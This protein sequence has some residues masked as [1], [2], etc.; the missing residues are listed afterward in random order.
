VTLISPPPHHDIYSIED[1]AQLIYDLKQINPIARVCVKL[2][3]QSGIGTVAAGV[4]KA[5]DVILISGHV[6][7]TGASPQTSIKY[8]R[9]AVGN[10]PRRSASGADAQQP[11]PPRDAA[12]RWRPPH[13]PRHRHRRDPRRGRV[14]HRH[15][16]LVA[17]GCIMVRQCHSN[18]CP[19]GVCTQ[20]EAL[21]AKF[22]GTPEK[23]VNLMSFIAEEVREILAMPRLPA[24]RRGDRPHRAA[25]SRSAAARPSRRS[26]SQPAAGARSIARTR[27]APLHIPAGPQRCAGQRSIAQIIDQDAGVCSSAARRCSSPST[28]RNTQR[29]IGTRFSAHVTREVR[30]VE[31]C[32][33]ASSP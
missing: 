3:A 25:P 8:R 5:G 24:P 10:G 15:A 4:A 18:T 1:L 11:A 32:R 7:G 33:T 22:T 12:H 14:R 27:Q 2:V 20:D 29:A 21:R 26:R 9:H 19:V 6:G 23:V 17:M 13:R 28:V 16:S 30:H 31:R